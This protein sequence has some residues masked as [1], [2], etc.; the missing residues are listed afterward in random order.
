MRI[1]DFGALGERVRGQWGEINRVNVEESRDQRKRGQRVLEWKF[2]TVVRALAR[3][4]SKISCDPIGEGEEKL[5]RA[6]FNRLLMKTYYEKHENGTGMNTP[7]LRRGRIVAV[8]DRRVVGLDMRGGSLRRVLHEIIVHA[9]FAEGEQTFYT[10]R[11]FFFVL[12][13]DLT[14]GWK[15]CGKTVL[16]SGTFVSF[17]NH[18]VT[19]RRARV[20][21][22]TQHDNTF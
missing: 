18:Q 5:F 2:Y 8:N 10:G 13:C 4:K 7:L 12:F 3:G 17:S 11:L 21:V 14:V 19:F 20:R 1:W 9:Y 15:L 22:Y 16:R 6:R